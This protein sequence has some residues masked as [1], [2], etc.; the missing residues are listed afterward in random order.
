[1]IVAVPEIVESR[2]VALH[3]AVGPEPDNVQGEPVKLPSDVE[4]VTVPAG[5]IGDPVV[6]VSV[7]VAVQVEGWFTTTGVLH[8]TLDEVLLGLTAMFAAPE[9]GEWVVSPP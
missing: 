5:V 3:V 9:L 8:D 6:E 4:K 2:N 7:T 1:M